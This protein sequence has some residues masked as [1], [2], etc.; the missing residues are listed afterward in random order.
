MQLKRIVRKRFVEESGIREWY[1]R[2]IG[3]AVIYGTINYTPI[4]FDLCTSTTLHEIF[5]LQYTLNGETRGRIK[6]EWDHIRWNNYYPRCRRCFCPGLCYSCT[7]SSIYELEQVQW[8]ES[9]KIDAS[10]Q[11]LPMWEGILHV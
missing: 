3:K 11:L 7:I 5:I 9:G 2:Y 8:K 6:Q 1:E 4:S 10:P